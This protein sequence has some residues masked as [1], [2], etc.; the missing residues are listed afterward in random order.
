MD[1]VRLLIDEPLKNGSCEECN[2]CIQVKRTKYCGNTENKNGK[3]IPCREMRVCNGFKRNY[4][5]EG[6]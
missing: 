4:M 6:Q 3:H 1:K 2:H 5:V